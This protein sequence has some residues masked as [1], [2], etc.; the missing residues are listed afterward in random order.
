MAHVTGSPGS[1][2][3]APPEESPDALQAVS[4]NRMPWLFGTFIVGIALLVG[5]KVFFAELYVELEQRG[6]NERSRLFIGDEIVREIG[7][8]ETAV[9]RLALADNPPALKRARQDIEAQDSPSSNVTSWSSSTVA[10]CAAK[11]SSTSRDAT[12]WFANSLTRHSSTTRPSSW[13]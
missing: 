7:S 9:Y 4:A 12:R 8:I 1:V 5:L 10:R 2:D 13:R 6:G 11:S 3:V